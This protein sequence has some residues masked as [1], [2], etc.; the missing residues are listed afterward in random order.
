M[1]GLPV[2]ASVFINPLSLSVPSLIL[3]FWASR[4][5]P[6]LSIHI[7]AGADMAWCWYPAMS[8]VPE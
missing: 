1:L 4:Y 6:V 8:M 2:T 7:S 5:M 3:I